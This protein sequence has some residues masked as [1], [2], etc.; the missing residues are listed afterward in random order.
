MHPTTRRK[1]LFG[2]ALSLGLWPLAL[3]RKLGAAEEVN[4]FEAINR[5]KDPANL[6]ARE[7]VHVPLISIPEKIQAGEPFE[8]RVQIGASPHVMRPD[9]WIE[10]I[11]VFI[12]DTRLVATLEMT[13]EVPLAA[14]TLPMRLS[15][16]TE[17]KVQ[18]RC[19]LHGI[20]EATKHVSV[21]AP[22]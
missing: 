15:E 1:F 21:R 4:L 10:T 13:P 11:W 18:A 17:I 22:D 5:A 8:L 2:S 7:A 12:A 14:L 9:H 6:S 20:W 16:A 3:V 19:N